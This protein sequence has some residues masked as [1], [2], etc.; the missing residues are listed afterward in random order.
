MEGII[1]YAWNYLNSIM[2]IESVF[3]IN[4]DIDGCVIIITEVYVVINAR[5]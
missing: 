4:A 2:A 3:T 1:I 5:D